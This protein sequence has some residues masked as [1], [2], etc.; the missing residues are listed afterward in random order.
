MKEYTL[1]TIVV[2]AFMAL[3]VLVSTPSPAHAAS[4][5]RINAPTKADTILSAP[6]ESSWANED[7]N[8]AADF[9]AKI[10]SDK[11]PTDVPTDAVENKA[12]QPQHLAAVDLTAK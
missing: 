7:K 4:T 3:A 5:F 12:Q 10:F 9:F 2:L 6:R 11:K 1:F 8:P